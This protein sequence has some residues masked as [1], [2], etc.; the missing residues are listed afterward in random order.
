MVLLTGSSISST[1]AF[2]KEA[3]EKIQCTVTRVTEV[4]QMM[5]ELF[6]PYR[7]RVFTCVIGGSR[8]GAEVV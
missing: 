1:M 7:R 5:E 4:E 8:S 3:R 6:P 2:L